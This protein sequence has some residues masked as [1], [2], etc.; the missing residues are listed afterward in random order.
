MPSWAMSTPASPP[1]SRRPA[2]PAADAPAP[3]DAPADGPAGADDPARADAPAGTAPD[4]VGR[5]RVL[6]YASAP[7]ADPSAVEAAYHTISRALDGTPG[8]L[9]NVLMR[10]LLDPAAFV[11]MS[12]WRDIASF[13]TWEEGAGHRDVTAPLRPL[14]DSAAGRGS[15]FGVYEITAA[16]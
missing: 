14:Q 13:R 9:G 15:A 2:P 8:L 4:P 16:Y 1:R 11:V 6:V 12:E 3:A 7:G 5:V 10:S